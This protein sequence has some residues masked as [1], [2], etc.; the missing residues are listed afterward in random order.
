MT[1]PDRQPDPREREPR[2]PAPK[3]PEETRGFLYQ[4]MLDYD[5]Y[6]GKPLGLPPYP[7][8]RFDEEG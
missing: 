7:G 5:A 6:Y 8:E 4:R 1:I 2:T 3:R